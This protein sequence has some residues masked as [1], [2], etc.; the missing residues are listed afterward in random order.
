M[1]TFNNLKGEK[2]LA[3]GK[4]LACKKP[5][6]KGK[7]WGQGIVCESVTIQGHMCENAMMKS[8]NV[9]ANVKI[10]KNVHLILL[11]NFLH[12]GLHV[13]QLA[14]AKFE[15]A[16][17]LVNCYWVWKICTLD[18]DPHL[19]SFNNQRSWRLCISFWQ[20]KVL[21]LV[22]TL[23]PITAGVGGEVN[24]ILT[25]SMK[26]YDSFLYAWFTRPNSLVIS[27]FPLS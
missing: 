7:E 19:R 20:G 13:L 10:F 17:R 9:C 11:A 8:T 2:E 4:Q 18:F 3:G 1:Y 26:L 25:K 27:V 14:E 22:K 15:N 6:E 5:V 21:T 16:N 23:E 12:L 24:I